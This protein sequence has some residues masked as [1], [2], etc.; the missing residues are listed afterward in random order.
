[1]RDKELG[2]AGERLAGAFLER[3]G[4]RILE[5]NYRSPH[6]ELDIIASK[7]GLLVF[8][9]VKTRSC[10]DIIEALEA[11]GP[12]KQERIVRTASYYLFREKPACRRCRFDVI[13]LL[14][15]CGRWRI[16]HVQ[17]AFEIGEI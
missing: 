9:E 2:R 8:C 16:E 1:M 10:G 14:R 7:G 13:A 5:R 17:D 6:G 15:E 12:R 11:V 3:K 4:Y